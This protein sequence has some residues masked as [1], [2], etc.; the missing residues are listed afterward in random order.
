ME[1]PAFTGQSPFRSVDNLWTSAPCRPPESLYIMHIIRMFD[2][3]MRTLS[4]T[5]GLASILAHGKDQRLTP[6]C[7]AMAPDQSSQLST[8]GR[9]E[10]SPARSFHNPARGADCPSCSSC[11]VHACLNCYI[12]QCE[13]SR[14]LLRARQGGQL[15]V[16]TV[17][18]SDARSRSRAGDR[19][20]SRPSSPGDAQK[21]KR[22]NG[23]HSVRARCS[24]SRP[25]V[26]KADAADSTG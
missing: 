10:R 20:G 11:N 17:S 8:G 21:R 1:A 4:T 14:S 12:S 15:V 23:A 24:R 7:T 18:Y 9:L 2:A 3:A 25:C 16:A 5:Y 13:I 22:P 6:C 26:R 19:S